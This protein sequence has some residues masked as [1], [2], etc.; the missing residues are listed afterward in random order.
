MSLASMVTERMAIYRSTYAADA[1]AAAVRSDAALTSD[2][3]CR[4]QTLGASEQVMN[5]AAGV[6]IDHQIFTLYQGV[7]HDDILV[8]TG[9]IGGVSV[10]ATVR[11]KGYPVRRRA[12]GNMTGFFVFN[13]EEVGL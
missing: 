12:I 1:V 9:L 11:V 8:I 4:D 7:Q 3:P 6:P 10:S 5:A 13:A 2:I